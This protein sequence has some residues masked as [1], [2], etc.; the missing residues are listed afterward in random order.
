MGEA[1]GVERRGGAAGDGES[2][3]ELERSPRD[4]AGE[5][6]FLAFEP[7]ARAEGQAD[8]ERQEGEGQAEQARERIHQAGRT[9]GRW[10]YVKTFDNPAGRG[11]GFRSAV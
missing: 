10:A 1:G 2:G 11:F 4:G 7:G 6:D 8:E 5:A 3:V 9:K